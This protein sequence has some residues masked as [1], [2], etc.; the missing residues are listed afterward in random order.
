[1]T[2]GLVATAPAADPP[3]YNTVSP[4][5]A[6]FLV[7]FVLALATIVLI[8]SMVGHLRKVRYGP[9]PDAA[10]ESPAP[11]VSPDQPAAPSAPPPPPAAGTQG[12]PVSGGPGRQPPG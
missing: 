10:G 7:I 11:E 9:D 12:P 2:G 5:I 4:G 8:R 3:S 1:M 6:G